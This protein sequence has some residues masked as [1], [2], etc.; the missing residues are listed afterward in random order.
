VFG[1]AAAALATTHI[2]ALAWL[3]L[4]HAVDL[5]RSQ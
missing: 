3:L 1:H 5:L 4:R 2:G